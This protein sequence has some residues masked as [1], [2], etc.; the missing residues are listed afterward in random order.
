MKVA[1]NDTSYHYSTV[2]PDPDQRS[3]DEIYK[4]GI[5]VVPIYYHCIAPCTREIISVENTLDL[6]NNILGYVAQDK[7]WQDESVFIENF[8]IERSDPERIKITF[9]NKSDT[10]T[11]KLIQGCSYG[12]IVIQRFRRYDDRFFQRM[13]QNFR[14]EII[15]KGIFI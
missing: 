3:G 9:V 6:P 13:K 15:P 8:F 11:L 7:I 12:G 4:A 10:K 1:G 2:K 5:C 14:V